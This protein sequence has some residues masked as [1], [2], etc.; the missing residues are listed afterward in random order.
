VIRISQEGVSVKWTREK[1]DAELALIR[2]WRR[3]IGSADAY[4]TRCFEDARKTLK[5]YSDWNEDGAI[6]I[7]TAW[8]PSKSLAE[9]LGNEQRGLSYP[10]SP[11]D[12]TGAAYFFLESSGGRLPRL[13]GVGWAS[14]T[15]ARARFMVLSAALVLF[16]HRMYQQARTTSNGP[17]VWQALYWM[18]RFHGNL[19]RVRDDTLQRRRAGSSN[20]DTKAKEALSNR[21]R[22]DGAFLSTPT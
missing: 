8:H 19:L 22:V 14:S 13:S 20:R 16:E 1:F 4:A 6:R 17:G 21:Q 10:Q 3:E 2:K 11:S 18:T 5:K 12:G 7:A 15:L 9:A